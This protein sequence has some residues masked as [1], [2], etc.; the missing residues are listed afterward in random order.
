[1]GK[2]I[3]TKKGPAGIRTFACRAT[4]VTERI[5]RSSLTTFKKNKQKKIKQ[6][7]IEKKNGECRISIVD[8]PRRKITKLLSLVKIGHSRSFEPRRNGSHKII[9]AFIVYKYLVECLL[10]GSFLKLD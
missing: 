1:M 10:Y 4:C 5:M 8:S 6:A 2:K 3:E 9:C 7:K